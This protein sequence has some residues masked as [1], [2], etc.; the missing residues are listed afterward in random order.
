MKHRTASKL[1]KIPTKSAPKLSLNHSNFFSNSS[2]NTLKDK[3]IGNQQ[4]RGKTLLHIGNDPKNNKLNIQS[5]SHYYKQF[6]PSHSYY[7]AVIA[8]TIVTNIDFPYAPPIPQDHFRRPQLGEGTK[9]QPS[10]TYPKAYTIWSKNMHASS[11]SIMTREEK[12][13]HSLG[14]TKMA[15]SQV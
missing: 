10:H 4:I 7:I 12:Q 15:K 2:A 9:S 6:V 13:S 11:V 5:N 3:P 8:P 1:F 14:L